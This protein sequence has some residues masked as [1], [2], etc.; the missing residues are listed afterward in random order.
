MNQFVPS[1][2]GR[3]FSV[4]FAAAVVSGLCFGTQAH[5]QTPTPV[6]KL[7]SLRVNAQ[8]SAAV[9]SANVTG[10]AA[11]LRR[12]VVS[13]NQPIQDGATLRAAVPPYS[14]KFGQAFAPLPNGSGWGTAAGG[15]GGTVRRT[16]YEQFTVTAAAGATVRVDSLIATSSFM[17]TSSGANLAVAYSRSN[18]ASDSTVITGGKGPLGPVGGGFPA[19]ATLPAD[20]PAPIPL[21]QVNT[22]TGNVSTYR[23]ALAGGSGVTINAGQTLTIRM[24]F[25]CSSTGVARYALL[26][27]V[28]VKSLQ[29]VVASSKGSTKAVAGLEVFPNPAQDKFVVNHASLR[30]EAR[31]NVYSV[32][33]QQV[34]SFVAKPNTNQTT[35][36]VAGLAQG[37]YVVEYAS[38]NARI[39]SR[40]IKE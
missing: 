40:L 2:L 24:Y 25:S 29:P 5:A 31:I 4:A 3:Q 22:T 17:L 39:T 20:G 23:L 36:S 26:K 30:N 12:F 35:V 28:L 9:R 13:D 37:V 34:A 10:S 15:P 19:T 18:F 32:T 8:D 1:R 16:F 11:T 33:G 7:W 38:D 27:D 6:Y 14:A 21:T